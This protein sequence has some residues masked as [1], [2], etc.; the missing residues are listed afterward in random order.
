MVRSSLSLLF[1]TLSSSSSPDPT[2]RPKGLL[3]I[4]N[5]CEVCGGDNA[6]EVWNIPP[7]ARG[8]HTMTL[9]TT[10]E[11]LRIRLC[12]ERTK[13]TQQ[14]KTKKLA[15]DAQE[16]SSS[17]LNDALRECEGDDG[18]RNNPYT[19]PYFLSH[20]NH[21]HT[22]STL[23]HEGHKIVL[24]HNH[25]ER[26]FEPHHSPAFL[27]FEGHVFIDPEGSI[28]V[29][30]EDEMENGVKRRRITDMG[31]FERSDTGYLFIESGVNTFFEELYKVKPELSDRTGFLYGN[32][33]VN[34]VKEIRRQCAERFEEAMLWTEKAMIDRDCGDEN[35]KRCGALAKH[36]ISHAD[37]KKALV[38]AQET[39]FKTQIE[40]F[41]F[42]TRLGYKLLS[43]DYFKRYIVN[44][45]GDDYVDLFRRMR[46]R[47]DRLIN[48]GNEPEAM[49]IPDANLNCYTSDTWMNR[50]TEKLDD[51]M[52]EFCR[53]ALSEWQTT[54]KYEDLIHTSSYGFRTYKRGSE[55]GNHV[56]RLSTHVLSCIFNIRTR[57]MHTPWYLHVHREDAQYPTNYTKLET[58]EGD[59]VLYESTTLWHGRPEPLDGEEVVNHFVHF[60]PIWWDPEELLRKEKRG[61]YFTK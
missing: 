60:R 36:L 27:A 19:R 44:R 6:V 4:T 9:K 13:T 30:Y 31:R 11:K 43:F 23:V 18:S 59:V 32:K 40:H 35:L 24:Q 17:Y 39:E 28:S 12:Q 52:I 10:R 50:P 56:D 55:L 37:Y 5:N 25:V 54:V 47:A 42:F 51:E 22:F 61:Y 26:D 49:P 41:P 33:F 46:Q 1:H 16:I 57:K 2:L 34:K 7:F 58:N 15:H 14:E 48:E 21:T 3:V 20:V 38:P 45:R 8:D 29:L 53:W